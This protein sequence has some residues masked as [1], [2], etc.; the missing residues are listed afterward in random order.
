[1]RRTLLALLIGAAA[2]P[3]AA[4]AQTVCKPDKNSNEVKL[5]GHYMVPIAFDAAEAP[6]PYRLASIRLGLEATYVPDLSAADRT[7]TVCQPGQGPLNTNQENVLFRPR[8]LLSGQ[9]GLFIELSWIP[10]VRVNGVKSNLVSFAIGRSTQTGKN[11]LARLRL[12]GVLGSVKGA[13]TCSAGDVA[14]PT[15]SECFNSQVSNDK[16]KPTMFGGDFSVARTMAGGRFIPYLGLGISFLRPRFQVSH[17]T[18]DSTTDNTKIEANMTRFTAHGG[19]SF[20]PSPRLLISAEAYAAPAD[21]ITG[22]VM[23]SW[24]FKAGK[25]G[26]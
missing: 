1:M 17:V 9:R 25:P 19:F 13:F 11:G 5:F 26:R 15:N 12:F 7:P 14:S 23:L 8:L 2:W 21:A 16:L 22:R 20:V 18:A 3:I 10:P 24:V 6:A 4:S